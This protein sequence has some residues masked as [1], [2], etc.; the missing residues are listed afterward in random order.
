MHTL[1]RPPA[2]AHSLILRIV[3]GCPWNQCTFCGMYKGV[4]SRFLPAE[5]IERIIDTAAR[6]YPRARRIFL[7][8]GDAMSLPI[9]RLLP[10][11][12]RINL[13]FTHLARINSYASGS[14][15]LSKRISELELLR[16]LRLNTLYMGLESGH[17]P[18][19]KR[20]GKRES[21][22]DMIQAGIN[23]QAAGL[24]MSVMILTGLGGSESSAMH[25]SD[26]ALALNRMQPKLLSALRVIP[27]P[28][29]P[30]Y[31]D[32]TNGSFLPLSEHAAIKELRVMISDM[33]LTGT[34]FRADHSSN[35]LPL[36]GRFPKDKVRLMNE[37]DTLLS[38]DRLDKD[39]PGPQPLFL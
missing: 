21:A 11:M 13:R 28:G 3:D 30:L 10:I 20:V 25:A 34:V 37:L 6:Q 15:I 2:E 12:E 32:V 18:T 31:S 39:G 22:T 8:D 17:E 19:L 35:I 36:E 26:T 38:S 1:F 5:E 14:S 16:Q 9:S 27:V 4:K 24:K 29:T 7:A 23:A 33:E